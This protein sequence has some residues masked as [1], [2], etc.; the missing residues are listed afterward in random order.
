M[1]DYDDPEAASQ[2]LMQNVAYDEKVMSQKRNQILATLYLTYAG[3]YLSRKADS[4]VKSSL[5]ELEGFTVEDLALGDTVYLLVYTVFL[6]FSGV[7]GD[8]IPSNKLLSGALVC[9]S[10]MSYLKSRVTSPF[11]FVSYQVLHAVFQS[12]GWPTCIKLIGVWVT[13]NRGLVMGFWTTCQSVGGILGALWATYMITHYSWHFA[14]LYMIPLQLSLALLCYFTVE[15]DPSHDK[16]SDMDEN[17]EAPERHHRPPAQEKVS[18]KEILAIPGVLSI[19]IAY[20]FLKFLRYALLMWLPYYYEE[21]LSF[22][23]ATAGYISTSFEMGGMIGTPLIGWF[24]DKHMHGSRDL[25]CAVFLLGGG[26]MLVACIVASHLGALYNAMSMFLVGILVIG[27]DSILSGTIAQDLAN[28]SGLGGKAMGTLAGL[29]NSMGSFG[30]IFQ[31]YATA[32]ISEIYGWEVLFTVFVVSA[33]LSS[34][35]LFRVYSSKVKI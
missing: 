22:D 29:I 4:V 15:D 20:F 13:Q 31:S 35:I 9:L 16:Q 19:G 32:Y 23:A 21:G 30:S 10:M 34:L 25:T 28:A 33:G 14:Y 11:W 3:F 12:A 8:A 1:N 24:S 6:A 27:P 5:H 7:F 17:D 26:L 18:V 2:R